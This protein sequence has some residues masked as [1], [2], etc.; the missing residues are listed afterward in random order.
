ME[1]IRSNGYEWTLV[2][3]HYSLIITRSK[4][5]TTGNGQIRKKL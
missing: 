2:G 1:T 4:R 3:C 5:K